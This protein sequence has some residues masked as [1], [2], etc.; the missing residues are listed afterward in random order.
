[1]KKLIVILTILTFN[2]G[3][4]TL[5]CFA[6]PNGGFENWSTVYNY[7]VPDNWA[8]L[9]FL[10]MFSPNPTSAFKATGLDKHSGSYALKIQTI[11]VENNPAPGSI[12]DTVGI[13]FTGKITLSPPA[14]KVGFPYSGRPEKLEFWSKYTPVGNDTAGAR[15]VLMKWNGIS[16]DTIAFGELFINS[17]VAYNIFQVPLT[18]YSSTA[19]PDT[20]AIIFGSSKREA[21]ARV[22]STLYIDDVAFTGWVGVEEHDR[23]S[24]K[25]K[26]FPN[27]ATGA[28][29]IY[30]KIDEADNIQILDV[31]SKRVGVYKIHN[32]NANIN[33]G[34]FSEGIYFYE[35]RDN[36]NRSLTKGKFNVIK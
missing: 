22:G 21:D 36:K 14:Y 26:T 16:R 33:T 20:A 34:L 2:L 6:Q 18:Y 28:I 5:N 23:F 29:N 8:T 9:N 3:L 19:V 31:S 12:D 11:F 17:T 15:I 13:T 30:A 32:Y 24:D 10:S 27:P 7:Q 1:M 35:I 25:V 4:L